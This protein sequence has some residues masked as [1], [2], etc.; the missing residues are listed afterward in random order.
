VR[1]VARRV[2][3]AGALRRLLV[4]P[5]AVVAALVFVTGASA[6]ATWRYE[7]ALAPPPPAGVAPAPYGVPL[8][9]VGEIS[10]WA[11]NRGLLITGGTEG[12]GGPVPGGLYAYDGVSWH[13]LSS[14]CGGAEGR[15]VWAGPD[16]FWTISDQRAGQLLGNS[17]AGEREAP[18]V[19]LCHFVEG[20]VVGSYAMPLEEVDSWSH[21]NGG[22]CY[23]PSDC[24]FGGEDGPPPNGAF[25][26][27][28]DGSTVTAVY[29]PEDHSVA[30]MVGFQGKLYESVQLESGDV[31]LTE[32]ERRHPA[33]IHTVA[34]AGAEPTFEN[35]FIYSPSAKHLL[36]LYG[37]KVLPE[38]L[39][40]FDLA[41]DGSGLGTDA[42]SLWAAANPSANPPAGSS[43]ASLTVLRDSDGS[44]SQVLPGPNGE[45][46]LG[47]ASLAG[48]QAS[49]GKR[50]ELGT[51]GAIAPEPGSGAAWLS[52]RGGG[53]TGAKVALLETD[54]KLAEPP[55]LLPS[56]NE[57]VGY[58]GE[59]GPLACAAPHDCWMA[60]IGETTA[61]SGW[62]FHLSDGTQPEPDSDPFFDGTDGV[63]AYR[64]PDSGVPIVYPDGF[65]EDDSLANQQPAP[66]PTAPPQPA[67]AKPAK[68]K[69]S[70]PLVK[71]VKSKFLDH[72]TLV[73]SFTLTARAHVQ[74][75]AR[76]DKRIVAKTSDESLRPGAHRLSL[77]LD[78]ARWPNKLQ[79]QAKPIGASAPSGGGS[80]SS[81]SG[82]TI[83]T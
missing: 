45:E 47:E 38:A 9:T 22:A 64:P 52:L 33:V 83:S 27:H 60:T 2:A 82:D 54:G 49:V 79:F 35:L 63:I 70:K 17:N 14:V 1:L 69:K 56:A 19:S 50:Q 24:W 34:P 31:W 53:G 42:T 29:E 3:A 77:S 62:L 40:G 16:E 80:E 51:S 5:F 76:K 68:A 26:L 65:A 8:G 7:P 71:D 72:R 81:D 37:E 74:L 23:D 67:P 41:T 39:S 57:D 28:W 10:F 4:A 6:D 21:M 58:R 32:E 48:S 25:H 46:P 20:Q 13:E 44:W 66:P 36:P 12:E 15:I 43:R 73:I 59:A 30:G 18:A 11:P 75:I 55:D 61:T 78:P